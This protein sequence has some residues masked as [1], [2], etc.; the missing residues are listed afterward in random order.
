MK[1]KFSIIKKLNDFACAKTGGGMSLI[2]KLQ[3]IDII[4]NNPNTMVVDPRGEI[5]DIV[6]EKLNELDRS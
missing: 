6:L 1:K 3:A 5:Q 4:N 2:C